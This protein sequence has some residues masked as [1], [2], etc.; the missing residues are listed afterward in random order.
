MKAGYIAA[1]IGAAWLLG[2]SPPVAAAPAPPALLDA[3]SPRVDAGT[4]RLDG[5]EAAAEAE[6]AAAPAAGVDHGA[7]AG[8]HGKDSAPRTNN[9]VTAH[10]NDAPA[11]SADGGVRAPAPRLADA[12]V[13]IGDAKLFVIRVER[14]GVT[15][16]DR[17]HRASLLLERVVELGRDQDVRVGFDGATAVIFVGPTPL[18]QLV[19]ED[20]DAA[21]DAS[22][23]V[24]A[25]AA[26]AAV[27]EGLR[28][29][30]RRREIAHIVFSI[31][32]IVLFGLAAFL[33]FGAISRVALRV[34]QLLDARETM[35]ALRVG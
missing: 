22:L 23:A 25:E 19:K 6:G 10:V 15:A 14:A 4:P 11:H 9:E 28:T 34:T 21:G 26:A 3:G 30:L 12:A 35:P 17:A 7:G 32:L 5:G 33:L 8:A 16:S 31:S 29:E 20:A 1:V 2:A 13:Q 18:V 27:R 24:H